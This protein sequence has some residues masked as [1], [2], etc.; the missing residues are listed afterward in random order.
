MFVSRSFNV[1]RK[2]VIEEKPDIEKFV[3]ISRINIIVINI[4]TTTSI[5]TSYLE[6]LLL[7]LY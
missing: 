2:N 1:S 4:I 6:I 3:R 5:N 7:F